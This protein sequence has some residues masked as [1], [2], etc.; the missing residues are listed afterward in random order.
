MKILVKKISTLLFFLIIITASAYAQSDLLITPYRVVFE[1]GKYIQEVSV[2]NTGKGS[3]NYIISFVQYKMN[4]EGVL[5]QI[6]KEEEYM[7]F[8]DKY[9][10]V[11][12]RSVILAPNEAQIV[13]LQVR[14]PSDIDEAEYRSHL[15]FRSIPKEEPE[16]MEKDADST[17]SVQLIPVYG[18]S[19]PVILRIGDLSVDVDAADIELDL[20]TEQPILNFRIVRDG[21]KSTFGDIEVNYL[22]TEGESK[23]VG[24]VRGVAI[25]TPLF[26]RKIS[27]KLINDEEVDYRNGILK[28]TYTSSGS[29]KKETYF[30]YLHGLK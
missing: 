28:I 1:D 19:I 18:I 3:S 5:I 21:D 15:Y 7:Y 9:I 29:S 4:D 12:P 23:K 25:Y 24:S 14:A 6:N 13:R 30:D 20:S 26:Y 27:M 17:L 16:G 2:A 11:F 22:N 10:R 8:A